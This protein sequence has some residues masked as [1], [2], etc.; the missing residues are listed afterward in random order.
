[1][2]I[3]SH[4]HLD[5]EAFD[6]DRDAVLESAYEAD[7]RHIVIPGVM[8]STWP[9]ISQLCEHYPQLHPCYGLHPYFIDRHSD[10]D[11]TSL[12]TWLTEH[13]AVA[14][15]ECGLD[16]YLKELDKSRQQFFFAAQLELARKHQLPVVIHA[17]KSTEDVIQAIRNVPGLSGMIHS[18]AGSYEQA[19]QLIDLGFYLSFGGPVTNPGAAKLHKLIRRLPLESILVETDAPDQPVASARG[20]RNEPA[21][22]TEVIQAI[23]ELQDTDTDEVAMV[24]SDNAQRLFQLV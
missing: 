11:I 19:I 4:C 2:I 23:A 10:D 9:R 22:I 1:M 8:A 17:R 20:Q 15:G 14:V 18:Y 16:Y 6:A 3:D 7:I 5:F 21:F 13:N 24:T 12:D